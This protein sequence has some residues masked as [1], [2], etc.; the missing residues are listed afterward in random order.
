MSVFKS[1]FSRALTVIASDNAIIPYPNVTKS[2][3]NTSLIENTLVDSTGFF[4]DNNVTRG[5]VVYNTTNGSAATV[6]Q[7]VGQTVIYLNADIFSVEG[8]SYIIYQASSQNTN[9]N[10]GCNLYVGGAGGLTVTT[11]GGDIVTF[12][13]VQ[14]GTVLPVQVIKLWGSSSATDVVALW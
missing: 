13:E 7:V 11:I 3:L 5:D 12:V 10:P 2:G 1:Q 4:L 14:K 9:G 8:S 6:T